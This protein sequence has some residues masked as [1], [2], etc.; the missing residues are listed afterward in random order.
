MRTTVR[1]FKDGIKR[2]LNNAFKDQGIWRASKTTRLHRFH[3]IGVWNDG[4]FLGVGP[5]LDGSKFGE[6]CRIVLNM[7]HDVP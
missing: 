6:D 4:R 2:I 1:A 5:N 3:T 7:I